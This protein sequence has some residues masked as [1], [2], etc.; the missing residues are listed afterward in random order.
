MIISKRDKVI[1]LVQDV[2]KF[3]PVRRNIKELFS[4]AYIK[5]VDRVSFEVNEG[6][7]FAIVG[8]SGCGKTT[9]G[10]LIAGLIRPSG[11]RIIFDSVEIT[12]NRLKG[13]LRRR[14]QMVFQN[15]FSSLNPKMKIRDLILEG[16][17]VHRLI[18]KGE[19]SAR[20]KYLLRAVGLDVEFASRY[21]AELS[22]G[23]LQRVAIARALAVEPQLLVA[24]EP[25]SSLDVSI[26]AQILK[27]FEEIR[28][29][30]NTTI[31][32]ISHDIHTVRSYS[33][34]VAVMYLGK[35][36]EIGNSQEIF[37]SPA[38][39]YTKLLIDSVVDFGKVLE[40]GRYELKGIEGEPLSP[41]NP[42]PGCRFSQR[43]PFRESIC[44]KEPEYVTV[45][46]RKVLCHFAGKLDKI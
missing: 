4:P 3:F 43:C 32:F 5:A 10:K 30:F 24:D 16:V 35:V 23:Q 22:G 8:E 37:E 42:P 25:T 41:L 1:L 13:D 17:I 18:P 31:I 27:L 39:P 36:V 29:K 9:L 45:G 38:H 11:G 19:L 26:R 6:E 28:E 15:P 44:D 33:D 34:R 40:S 12:K 21:P 20:L 14:I 7:F 46:S 2:K